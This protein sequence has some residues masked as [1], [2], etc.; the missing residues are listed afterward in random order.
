MNN[1]VA[2]ADLSCKYDNAAV[3]CIPTA[4]VSEELTDRIKRSRI[5]FESTLCQVNEITLSGDT[6]A[7]LDPAEVR[8][9]V[10]YEC[11][12]SRNEPTQPSATPV[13]QITTARY[14]FSC[15][16]RQ[17]KSFSS[18]FDIFDNGRKSHWDSQGTSREIPWRDLAN[19][20]GDTRLTPLFRTWCE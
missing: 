4:P 1:Q 19:G 2:R 13:R 18:G 9:L 10:R 11:K 15:A 5:L 14:Q 7:K 17:Y 8:M 12:K 16:L 6:E 3:A 20:N